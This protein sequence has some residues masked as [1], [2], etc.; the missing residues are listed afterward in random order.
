MRLPGSA[1][2]ARSL[3]LAAAALQLPCSFAEAD[4]SPYLD[5][6]GMEQVYWGDTHLHT[7]YSVDAGMTGTTAD[8]ETAYRFALGEEVV[9]SSGLRARIDR[10][11]DFLVVADHAENLGLAPAIENSDPKLLAVPWGR[12]IHDLVKSGKRYQALEKWGREAMLPLHD[13]LAGSGMAESVWK[14]QVSL[15]DQFNDPGHFT[16]LIG[17]EWSSTAAGNNLH[18]VVIF[19]DDADRAGQVIP[20]SQ[21]DS[22]DPEALWDWLEDYQARTGGT[23]LAI[24][25]NGNLSNGMMFSPVRLNGQPIDAGY[26]R[27][28][29]RWEPLVEVTQIKGNGETHP[30]LSPDDEFAAAGIWDRSNIAGAAPRTDDM[31]QY[32]YARAALK[33]GLAIEAEIGIN[34]FNF[35]LLGSTDSHT[36]LSTVREDNY[37]G[38]LTSDEPAPG[39]WNHYLFKSV[40]DD[41]L[42]T[43]TSD[44]LAAGLA[45]VWARENTREAIF[46]A[47]QRREV[48]ASTGPRI[49][50][51]V[52]AGWG[53]TGS[54]LNSPDMA[55]HGYSRGVPMGGSLQGAG[56][57]AAD[58]PVFMITALRDPDGANLDR[59]Q[60]VKGWLNADGTTQEKVYNVAVS[61]KRRILK[62]RVE[63][64][65][66][67]VDRR[68]ATYSNATGEVSL[69]AL[70]KDPDFDPAERAFYYA[71][72]LQIPTPS[73]QLH[74]EVRFGERMPDDIPREVQD[75]VYTSPI[76]YRP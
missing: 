65:Q 26:A 23:A 11:L 58:A 41:S 74:D 33:N 59:I 62:N 49:S 47:L 22:S 64:L 12:D 20:F 63:P 60:M 31:L 21:Y 5:R 13:Y 51:R 55:R 19:R 54:D 50:V 40:T 61:D 17:F 18:R 3:V 70:W 7:S 8:P 69:S 16:A 46:E 48:Y 68:T 30:K 71:R 14:R 28:R 45:G 52:F 38:K 67:T 43:R 35:G 29:A 44:E 66:S 27:R 6:R 4:Y 37:F 39:R 10:P 25:H 1:A 2:R 34:P 53:F 73:W 57:G 15:A 72:V 75:R 32:E 36:A 24:P 9:A 56:R 42:S 76:W